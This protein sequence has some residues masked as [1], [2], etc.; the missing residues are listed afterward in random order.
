MPF[1]KKDGEKEN[2]NKERVNYKAR[3]EHKLYLAQESPEPVFD[4]SECAL[5]IVPS[6][7]FYRCK[8]MRKQAILLQENELVSLS[9]GGNLADLAE[10]SLLDLHN[11]A[12]EKLPEDV[13]A[14]TKLT[15]LYLENNK[16][17]QLPASI[18]SLAQLRTL[19][20]ANNCIKELPAAITN[21][22]NL[23]TLDLRNNPK[24]KK[25]PVDI[26]RLRCLDCLLVDPSTLTYP[27]PDVTDQG[28]EA[29]MRFLCQ[30]CDI[31]YI[32]PS[33][34]LPLEPA[35]GNTNG[36]NITPPEDPLQDM[37]TSHLAKAERI[38]EQKKQSAKLLEDQINLTQQSEAKLKLQ[39]EENK[40]KLLE[41]LL[42]EGTKKEEEMKKIQQNRHA[43]QSRLFEAMNS[44]EAQ[45]DILITE[46]VAQSIRYSDPKK[47]MEA[48]ETERRE[49]ERKFTIH[50]HDVEK[51][52]EAEVLRSMQLMMED[53][54]QRESTRRQ[55]EQRQGIVQEAINSSL[56]NDKAIEAVL[57]SKGKSQEIL[58]SKL[59]EDEKYQREAFQSLLLHQDHRSQEIS[60]QM[61]KIQAEL[62]SLTMVEMKKRDLK[63]EFEMEV[64]K[65]KRETLTKILLDLIQKKKDRADDLQDLL[66]KIEEEKESEQENYWLIQY[67][68]LLDSKPAGVQ[69][70]EKNLDP[71]VM[72]ILDAAG[73]ENLA[74]IFGRAGVT[75]KAL[76]CADHKAL[77]QYGVDSEYTRNQILDALELQ[78][79][80][81]GGGNQ[82][83]APD[84]DLDDTVPSAP[85]DAAEPSA[86][87]SNIIETF[88]TGECVVCLENKSSIIFLPCGHLCCCN[89]CEQQME[90][91]PLCRNTILQRVRLG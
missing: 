15:T 70:A 59:L 71:Q 51:L 24:L 2:K 52:K 87:P 81:E 84:Q 23:R 44:A 9:G 31:E 53:E 19:N 67:Q 73:A 7:I 21:L 56:D 77:R 11:N 82:P 78:L 47:V 91:C 39:S 58:I 79:A 14:L 90:S 42:Q 10:I 76:C 54:L 35:A 80:T 27:P 66:G 4:L 29:I 49:M 46:L 69:Q 45:T 60:G 6:G 33:Q 75:Y 89:S 13:G 3:L 5:K 17:K 34:C 57:S 37:V 41:G 88:Q 43:E 61:D 30:E 12:L 36:H 50:Q 55:Y 16:L 72:K 40:K 63:V 1:W 62:A 32:S 74:P 28:T 64:L 18:G 22:A 26:C 25:L 38:K 86:P 20:L 85:E 83:S 68:K 48:L 8:I 65:D